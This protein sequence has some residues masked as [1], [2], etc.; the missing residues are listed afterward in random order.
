MEVIPVV[1]GIATEVAGAAP[2]VQVEGGAT[3]PELRRGEQPQ[4]GP[5]PQGG[6]V[7]LTT[8]IYHARAVAG[9]LEGEEGPTRA[10]ADRLVGIIEEELLLRKAGAAKL[11]TNEARAQLAKL[12][13]ES[14]SWESAY[15]DLQTV[16]VE[17][18]NTCR[19]KELKG[20][21][22]KAVEEK[23]SLQKELEAERAK[24]GAEK[25][26]FQKELEAEKAKA[27]AEKESLQKE[28]EAEKAKATVERAT[29]DKELAEE[30]AKTA[31]E[32][33]AYPDL[34]VAAVDQFKGSA[35]F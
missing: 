25:E 30:R 35:E 9:R 31:S 2:G 22:A 5:A 19:Q 16:K 18:E 21:R 8:V 14:A 33:V 24:A 6:G 28:L 4:G 27:T 13:K 11:K 15:A 32:R 17:L 1:V 20:E 26:S 12:K 29:L 34:Y 10:G 23:E 3:G 7:S